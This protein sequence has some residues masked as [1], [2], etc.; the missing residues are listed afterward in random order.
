MGPRQRRCVALGSVGDG[1]A[2]KAEPHLELAITMCSCPFVTLQVMF[3]GPSCA[4]WVKHLGWAPQDGDE[5]EILHAGYGERNAIPDGY[6][7]RASLA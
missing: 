6:I 1:K 3:G 2:S 4:F 5:M 7:V